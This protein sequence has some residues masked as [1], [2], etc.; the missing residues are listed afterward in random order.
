MALRKIPVRRQCGFCG[1]TGK[2]EEFSETPVEDERWCCLQCKEKKTFKVLEAFLIKPSVLYKIPADW[3]IT[4]I[5]VTYEGL[6]YKGEL[7]DCP[8]KE[9]DGELD[10]ADIQITEDYDEYFDCE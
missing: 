1:K 8:T 5:Y 2:K 4:D 3:D 7:V 6:H 10:T 9:I